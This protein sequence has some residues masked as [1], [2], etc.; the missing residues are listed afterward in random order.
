MKRSFLWIFLLSLMAA[1]WAQ[2]G[3]V[4]VGA[5]ANFRRSTID[6]NNYQE[7]L[8]YTGSISYY[9]WE[10]SALEASYTEGSALLSVKPVDDTKIITKSIFRMV[11]LDLV[12]TFGAKE[13]FLNPYIKI[14]G[15]HIEKKI[16]REPDGLNAS[17][18]ESPSSVVP[19][20]GLGFKMRLTK[21]LTLKVGVDGWTSSLKDDNPTID[22]AGRA[23]ISWMF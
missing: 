7:S 1:P 13:A 20:A 5:S 19:S 3:V 8:S 21:T 4:E 12:I 6:D 10:M 15:A 23:G 17:E 11:G 18:I 16:V 22:Y 2:A 9:F 14:G